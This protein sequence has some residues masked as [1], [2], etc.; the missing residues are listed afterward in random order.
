[1]QELTTHDKKTMLEF[2]RGVILANLNDAPLPPVPKLELL[3]EPGACFVT[4][5]TGSGQ[6]RGCIGTIIPHTTLGNDMQSNALNAA[7]RDPR[8]PPLMSSNEFADIE[9]E[10]SILTPMEDIESPEQFIVGEHGILMR[11]FGRS[12]VFLPQVAPEQGWDRDT[13][14]AHLSMKAGF[15]PGAWKIEDARFQVFRAI[16]F[17]ESETN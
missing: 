3:K 13:T 17:S 2:V 16:H 7:F 5:H 15:K 12:A 11:L 6:L 1:M 14:L 4:L 8:F 10:I 9:I